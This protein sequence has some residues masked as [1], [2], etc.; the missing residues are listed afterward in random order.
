M[1]TKWAGIGLILAA[2]CFGALPETVKVGGPANPFDV[3]ELT[4]HEPP[5]VLTKNMSILGKVSNSS[6]EKMTN[7]RIKG[8][9]HLNHGAALEGS[10]EVPELDSGYEAEFHITPLGLFDKSNVKTVTFTVISFTPQS[11]I[12][13]KARAVVARCRNAKNTL[14]NKAIGALTVNETDLIAACKAA[15]LW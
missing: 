14:G 13:R 7:I 12:D 3:Y 6:T 9:V 10:F 2:S 1:D 5:K 8:T 11:E 4:Y 15:K